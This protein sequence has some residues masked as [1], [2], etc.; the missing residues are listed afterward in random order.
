MINAILIIDNSSQLSLL[1]KKI[2][3]CCPCIHIK[4]VA[5]SLDQAKNLLQEDQFDLIILNLDELSFS[6]FKE[7]LG[8]NLLDTELIIISKSHSQALEAL[9]G[10]SAEY[11]CSP[12]Q[13]KFLISSVEKVR[14]RLRIREENDNYKIL[15]DK[16]LS[17]KSIFQFIGIPTMEGF[18]FF[19]PNE[20]VR[21]EGLQKCTRII[22]TTKTD[23]ISSYNI[24]EF[25][26]LLEPYGFFAPHKSHLINLAFV[27][28]YR[29]EGTLILKDNSTIPVAKRRKSVFLK[30]VIH[31]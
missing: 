8:N 23:V 10:H 27:K 12:I 31:L 4:A 30:Q 20:I 17:E 21:C 15:V 14:E 6:N 9:K 2:A 26:K 5:N 22:T 18:A 19:S 11:L 3:K 29:R 25:R 24:G 28:N 16:L 7:G 1:T 13:N